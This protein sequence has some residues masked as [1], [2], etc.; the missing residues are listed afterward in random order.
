M[1]GRQIA[2]QDAVYG[3]RGDVGRNEIEK[4]GDAGGIGFQ[5]LHIAN[6]NARPDRDVEI[7]GGTL[8]VGHAVLHRAITVADALIG[9]A[10]LAVD[11]AI[12]FG[13]GNGL[14][15]L[16]FPAAS[17][18]HQ[19]VGMQLERRQSERLHALQGSMQEGGEPEDTHRQPGFGILLQGAQGAIDIKFVTPLAGTAQGVVEL[20]DGSKAAEEIGGVG[21]TDLPVGFRFVIEEQVIDG[22][23]RRVPAVVVKNIAHHP[24]PGADRPGIEEN[25]RLL[26]GGAGG[27]QVQGDGFTGNGEDFVGLEKIGMDQRQG[28]TVAGRLQL[29][30]GKAPFFQQTGVERRARLMPGDDLAHGGSKQHI[31]RST[32]CVGIGLIAQRLDLRQ[33][34]GIGNT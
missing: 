2:H 21:G 9:N 6:E 5:G 3:H 22:V 29:L 17:E 25:L 18:K 23:L 4:A 8:R 32:G 27:G 15:G 33:G 24:L 7:V 19:G 1:P 10:E 14:V 30:A 12:E 13:F 28:H 26:P 31:A 11:G 16:A 20:M 34:G